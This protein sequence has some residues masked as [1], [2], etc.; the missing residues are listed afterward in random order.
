MDDL[1]HNTLDVAIALREVERTE[2]RRGLVE[3][4]VGFELVKQADVL[5]K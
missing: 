5:S 1:L 3:M 4:G 2:L